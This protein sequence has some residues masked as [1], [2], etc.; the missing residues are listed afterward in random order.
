MDNKT[1]NLAAFVSAFALDFTIRTLQPEW[2]PGNPISDIIYGNSGSFLPII[3]GTA[4][5]NRVADK[6]PE[7]KSKMGLGFKREY[8]FP[9]AATFAATVAELNE[10]VNPS[11]GTFDIKDLAAAT[12]G[13]LVAYLVTK[14]AYGQST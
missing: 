4:C 5:L 11:A 10:Y 13:G 12:A 3:W 7:M 1:L 2:E 8:Y 6:V 9:L 14:K